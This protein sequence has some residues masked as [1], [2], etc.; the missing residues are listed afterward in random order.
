MP[1]SLSPGA[2]AACSRRAGLGAP[3]TLIPRRGGAFSG[4]GRGGQETAWRG[5]DARQRREEAGG[6]GATSPS[7]YHVANRQYLQKT[8]DFGSR[9]IVAIQIFTNRT[10]TF[11]NNPP[12]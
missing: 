12:F 3:A 8:P 4:G 9:L 5:R 10:L 11:T 1:P 6:G 7:G 2:A